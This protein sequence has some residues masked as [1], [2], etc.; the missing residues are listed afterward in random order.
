[1][2]TKEYIIKPNGQKITVSEAMLEQLV[3]IRTSLTQMHTI[4]IG[5]GKS[6]STPISSPPKPRQLNLARQS[7]KR[8]RSKLFKLT[9]NLQ[10]QN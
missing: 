8:S 6:S 1:M 10:I 5:I 3:A 2:S 4:L 7:L 9:R